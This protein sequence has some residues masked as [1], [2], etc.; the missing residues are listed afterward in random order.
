MDSDSD[1]QKPHEKAFERDV[2]NNLLDIGIY[3]AALR[4]KVRERHQNPEKYPAPSSEYA[5]LARHQ[6]PAFR[7]DSASPV[8]VL[9]KELTWV[10]LPEAMQSDWDASE[11]IE[12]FAWTERVKEYLGEPGC[13]I[14]DPETDSCHVLTESNEHLRNFF[15]FYRLARFLVPKNKT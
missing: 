6:W 3:L 10:K 14:F 8:L 5:I 15:A 11:K 7:E 13:D 2:Q 4:G 12:I 1:G 9:D